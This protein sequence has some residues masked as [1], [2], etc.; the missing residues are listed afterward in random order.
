MTISLTKPAA[1]SVGWQAA[2]NQNFTDIET[3]I[4][5]GG[6]VP[7]G[8]IA[9]Y[10]GTSAPSGWLLCDGSAVSR[11]T[12]S[13]LFT[14]ISTNFGVGDGSTTFNVPDL[15]SR[16]PLGTGQGSGLSSRSIGALVPAGGGGETHTLTIGEMPA[17]NHGF[18]SWAGSTGTSSPLQ[19]N[20]IN[21]NGLTT[22]T[23]GGGGAHNNMHP[24]QVVTF[25]IKT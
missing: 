12:Y 14:A 16:S 23:V 10:G 1:G 2:I 24:C 20:G 21:A 17:H 4:N 22:Y 18:D 11:S 25:I 13:A 15:R 8:S 9:M 3:A 19:S 5:S 6:G 7:T